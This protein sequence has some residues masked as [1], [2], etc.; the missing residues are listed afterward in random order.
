[1]PIPLQTPRPAQELTREFAIKGGLRL[2]L[3][4]VL[5][6]VRVIT[7]RPRKFAMGFFNI[8]AAAG[9]RS[10]IA[11][12]NNF[13]PTQDQDGT[14]LVH[15]IWLRTNAT[16]GIDLAWPTVP[17][18][19]LTTVTTTRFTDGGRSGTPEAIMGQDNTAVAT[20]ADPFARLSVLAGQTSFPINFDPHPLVI[21]SVAPRTLLVRPEIDERQF[22][23]TIEWSEPAD[24]A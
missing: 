9:F 3:D 21:P 1:M 17:V 4:E 2:L 11:L 20:A 14:V 18:L 15:R 24:P 16:V 12:V 8:P 23:I 6:P 13:S 22:D 5:Y 7:D 19:G 10:E